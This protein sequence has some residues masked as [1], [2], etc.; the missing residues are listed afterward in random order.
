ME[1]EEHIIQK[2][3]LNNSAVHKSWELDCHGEKISYGGAQYSWVCSME[4]A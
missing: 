2:Y 4:L 1:E 3:E